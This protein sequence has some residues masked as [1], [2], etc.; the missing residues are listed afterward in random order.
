MLTLRNR[1]AFALAATL[2]TVLVP[3]A[4]P[5]AQTGPA[6]RPPLQAPHL[7]PLA[8]VDELKSWFNANSAHPRLVLLLSPT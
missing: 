1:L 8:G 6:A 5:A 2:L 3:N 7:Q 4:R